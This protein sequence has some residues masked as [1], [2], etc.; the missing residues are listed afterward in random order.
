MEMKN[1]AQEWGSAEASYIKDVKSLQERLRFR[2]LLALTSLLLVSPACPPLLFP[3][4]LLPILRRPS[5]VLPPSSFKFSS[6]TSSRLTRFP[7]P[8]REAC[9]HRSWS[10]SSSRRRPRLRCSQ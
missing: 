3:P 6:S 1:S 9:R 7:A 4:N 8:R 2:C 5:Y 10:G